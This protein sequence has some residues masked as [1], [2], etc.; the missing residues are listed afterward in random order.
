[1]ELWDAYKAD[2]TL[3]G[4]ELVRGEKIP[5]GCFHMV[6]E[7]VIQHVDGDFLLMQRSFTKEVYPGAWEIGAGGSALK[8]ESRLEAV[9]REVREETGIDTGEFEEIYQL[10]QEKQQ[11]I[12]YGYLL[13]TDYPK[14]AIQLQEGETIDY[15]WLTKEEF[16]EFY[17]TDQS[18]PTLKERLKDFVDLIRGV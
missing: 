6:C 16:I 8:G 13:K 11:A 18:I 7:A 14:D 10:V 4:F 1:M 2:G 17:D 9:F 15:K 5:A 3:A 12:Y